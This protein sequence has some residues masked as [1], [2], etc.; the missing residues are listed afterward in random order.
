MLTREGK[1]K[2]IKLKLIKFNFMNPNIFKTNDIRGIYGK[3]FNETDCYKIV[4]A[5]IK[6]LKNNNLNKK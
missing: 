6:T 2:L 1:L 5:F 4:L 3:D